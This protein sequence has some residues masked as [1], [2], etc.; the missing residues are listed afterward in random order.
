MTATIELT[1]L[2]KDEIC[3][4]HWEDRYPI[5]SESAFDAV[6]LGRLAA[7]ELAEIARRLIARDDLDIG[8]L[9]RFRLLFLWAKSGGTSGGKARWGSV[10]L[11]NPDLKH[12]TE[13]LEGQPADAVIRLAADNLREA[14]A[15]YWQVANE[16]C[17]FL[18][19]IGL[20]TTQ[21]GGDDRLTLIAP[22]A[23]FFTP[24]MRLFGPQTP[25]LKRTILDIRQARFEWADHLAEDIARAESDAAFDPSPPQAPGVEDEVGPVP[26]GP[27]AADW[28]ESDDYAFGLADEFAGP[29]IDVESAGEAEARLV[30]GLLT[31]G[32]RVELV[33]QNFG[34]KTDVRD[35]E[36]VLICRA[37]GMPAIDHDPDLCQG[38]TPQTRAKRS[39]QSKSVKAAA[40]NG[41]HD[42]DVG[43][44]LYDPDRVCHALADLGWTIAYQTTIDNG[45]GHYV[46]PLNGEP[47]GLETVEGAYRALVAGR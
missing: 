36:P 22:D 40:P 10:A 31:E 41:A 19:R 12:V 47:Y 9:D 32:Q 30:D 5:P 37:C 42:P 1:A 15:T 16:L 14:H 27:P 17:F 4:G 3:G 38:G 6:G 29:E 28:A 21:E 43:D 2:E 13:R 8:H 46:N 35:G 45:A 34:L 20:Y 11:A 24:Q 44:L 7:P 23:A 25:E 26:G 33:R 39:R 18:C